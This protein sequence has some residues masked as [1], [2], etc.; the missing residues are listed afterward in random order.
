[1][2][3]VKAKQNKAEDVEAPKSVDIDKLNLTELKAVAYDIFA[4][5]EKAQADLRQVNNLIKT[6]S[7]K[8][9]K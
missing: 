6:K 5:I 2:S 3:K 9:I 1:M 8:R 4:T 7:M